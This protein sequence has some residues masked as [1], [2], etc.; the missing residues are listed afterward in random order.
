MIIQHMNNHRVKCSCTS[1]DS[2]FREFLCKQLFTG[3]QKPV[4]TFVI[5]KALQQRE[6]MREAEARNTAKETIP[7]R[8]VSA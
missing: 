6:E 2:I 1:I 4:R 3:Q 7:G 8:S 5:L